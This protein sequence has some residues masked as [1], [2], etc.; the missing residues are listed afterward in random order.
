MPAGIQVLALM[1]LVAIGGVGCGDGSSSDS[2]SD[3]Y[4]IDDGAKEGAS[5]T[6]TIPPGQSAELVL[7]TGAALSLPAGAVGAPVAI[8]LTRPKDSEAAVLVQGLQTASVASAP[9]VITPHGTQF[10]QPVEITL[11]ISSSASGKDLVIAWRA[12]EDDPNWKVLGR[13]TVQDGK[14][15]FTVTHLSVFVVMV[16][17]GTLVVPDAGSAPQDAGAPPSDAGPADAGPPAPTD[18]AAP[19]ADAG[20][21]P[22]DAGAA[23]SDAGAAPSDAGPVPDAGNPQDA[24]TG[25]DASSPSDAGAA[26]DAAT[27]TDAAVDAAVDAGPIPDAGAGQDAAVDAGTAPLDAAVDAATD[28]ALADA[29]VVSGAN[30]ISAFQIGDVV[31]SV[32]G[33]NIGITVPF[34]TSLE[35]LSPTITITGLT[36]SPTSGTPRN[37]AA[38]VVYTV[39]AA[40][41]STR[42][43]TVTVT[44]A[45]STAKQITAFT[46]G[47][48]DGVISGATIAVTVPFGS[49]VAMLAPAFTIDGASVDPEPGETVDFTQP[50]PYTVTAADGSTKTYTVT[51]TVAPS[52][53]KAVTA[54]ALSGAAGVFTG[55][56]IAVT[57]PYGT[58]LTAL[59]PTTL[60][61]TGASISPLAN[62][63]QNFTS[64]VVYTVTAAD[65]TTAT[66]TVTVT[67]APNPAKEITAFALEGA[68]GVF[69]GNNIAVTVPFGTNVMAMTPTTLTTTG[70]SIAPL[71]NTP[72][73]FT[74]PVVYTVTAANGTTA[75]YTV[76]VSIAPSTA[77]E[78][79]AF[80]LAGVAGVF[81]GNNIAVTVPYGTNVM[82]MTP[83]TFTTTGASTSPLA[84]APQNFTSPVVYTV[85]AADGTMATYTVTVTVAPNPAKEITAFA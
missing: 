34:G 62:A 23:P 28:A 83:T 81:T 30:E 51:V 26:P 50:V 41:G 11:P 9:Y 5:S 39:T 33:T 55:N 56:N 77:K 70:A 22:A 32:V 2:L 61:T 52:T 60:T 37:F 43:Y 65:G 68:A 49:N 46:I 12:S 73:N 18:A 75:T 35:A 45:P 17:D 82:A 13:A 69:T 29:A 67:V 24:G 78:I 4:G 53:A 85:T 57:V 66:Y 58:T 19:P 7:P 3:K 47:E 71:A 44:V 20:A 79:T 84:N 64:P 6:M 16:D 63:P 21:A 10:L 76:T 15:S 1:A 36:V 31:G 25:G 59:T 38:P 14:A 80:A 42:T 27:I 8:A 74:S 54:F 48:V 72:Q 40:D